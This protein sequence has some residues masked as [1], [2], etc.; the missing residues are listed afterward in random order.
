MMTFFRKLGQCG[1]WLAAVALSAGVW[2]F[3]NDSLEIKPIW[4]VPIEDTL[5]LTHYQPSEKLFTGYRGKSDDQIEL[6]VMDA[7]SGV[8]KARLVA[9]KHAVPGLTL[10]R[11][12]Q[13]INFI[14]TKRS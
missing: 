14:M 5:Q 6:V 13:C 9:P 2:W 12:G 3:V 10:R 11:K 7:A 8:E 1:Y 4:I